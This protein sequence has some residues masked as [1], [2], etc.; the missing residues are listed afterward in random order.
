MRTFTTSATIPKPTEDVLQ[1]ALV[2]L[3]NNGFAIVARD[4]YNA[5]LTGPGLNS[6][7]Q[8]PLLGASKITLAIDGDQLK[9]DAEIGSALERFLKWLPLSVGLGTGLLLLFQGLL[10]GY[11]FGVGFGVPQA[12]GWT[13]LWICIGGVLFFA[14]PGLVLSEMMS[15]LVKGN[16]EV[17]LTNLISN[18]K[19]ISNA[20]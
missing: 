20:V 14:L 6:T 2:I 3:T 18:A 10:F 17:A 13:W 4:K 16:T 12:Q 5:V 15:S 7:R 9:L 1:A 19:Q 11:K 8:N